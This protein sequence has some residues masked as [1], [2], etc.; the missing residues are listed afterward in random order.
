MAVFAGNLKWATFEDFGLCTPFTTSLLADS[1]AAVISDP[2]VPQCLWP[3][4]RDGEATV[5]LETSKYEGKSHAGFP[6]FIYLFYFYRD[7][8]NNFNICFYSGL[9]RYDLGINQCIS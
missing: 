9:H 8:H 7:A 2:E 5:S 4:F 6:V 3:N 1:A